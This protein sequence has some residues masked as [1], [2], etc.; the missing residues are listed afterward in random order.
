MAAYLPLILE[1]ILQDPETRILGPLLRA[2][3]V[4]RVE[5]GPAPGAETQA[6]RAA[7]RL[8][9]QSQIDLLGY[10]RLYVD[11]VA[12]EMDPRHHVVIDPGNGA[13]GTI[14]LGGVEQIERQ[15]E[16]KG[17]FL[18]A[19]AAGQPRRGFDPTDER[20]PV[21]VLAQFSVDAHRA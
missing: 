3:A 21:R 16:R 15:D 11:A 8:E 20:D 19:P 5:I 14:R 10:Q 6:V 9:R 1:E 4:A 13:R 18:Q 2:G 17:V 12:V 7:Q